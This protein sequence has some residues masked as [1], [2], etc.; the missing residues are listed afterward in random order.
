M[1]GS[2]GHILPLCSPLDKDAL[3]LCNRSIAKIHIVH[4]Q[5]LEMIS[6]LNHKFPEA[7]LAL[8]LIITCLVGLTTMQHWLCLKA[9]RMHN[10]P[11]GEAASQLCEERQCREGIT[12]QE[13]MSHWQVSMV[14]HAFSWEDNAGSGLENITYMCIMLGLKHKTIDTLPHCRVTITDLAVCFC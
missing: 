11:V 9:S 4:L 2:P 5:T 3:P 7:C 6:A 12:L 8:L 1:P 13:P 14:T 10:Q